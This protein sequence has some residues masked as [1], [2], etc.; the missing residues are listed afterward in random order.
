MKIGHDVQKDITVTNAAVTDDT[1]AD[2]LCTLRVHRPTLFD[3]VAGADDTD[4]VINELGRSLVFALLGGEAGFAERV[5][6]SICG[7]KAC[8]FDYPA[9]GDAKAASLLK[10]LK[11]KKVKG[12]VKGKAWMAEAGIREYHVLENPRGEGYV[13]EILAVD[14]KAARRQP[15]TFKTPKAAKKAARKHYRAAVAKLFKKATAKQIL[16]GSGAAPVPSGPDASTLRVK[17]LEF[18]EM[19]GL[20]EDFLVADSGL[21]TYQIYPVKGA[22]EFTLTLCQSRSKLRETLSPFAGRVDA[23]KAAEEH[24]IAQVADLLEPE[25]AKRTKAS[26][27]LLADALAHI[28]DEIDIYRLIKAPKASSRHADMAKRIAAHLAPALAAVD[29]FKDEMETKS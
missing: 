22:K 23:I 19:G 24:H 6:F 29:L 11:F 26:L 5:H 20:D 13:L 7:I 4:G 3:T 28:P 10:P 15:G 9:P 8:D 18:E 27:R 14:E 12:D 17:P 21:A 1:V 16:A 25:D 2:T